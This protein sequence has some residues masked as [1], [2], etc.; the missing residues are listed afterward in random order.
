[1]IQPNIRQKLLTSPSPL[2]RIKA[3]C[4]GAEF[5]CQEAEGRA[6]SRGDDESMCYWRG[7]IDGFRAVLSY[8]KM[9]EEK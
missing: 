9:L 7:R 3:M 8:L 6:V 4:Q 5:D 2:E 1:M